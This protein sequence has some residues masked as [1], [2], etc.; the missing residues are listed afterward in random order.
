MLNRLYCGLAG[1][2]ACLFVA[3]PAWA[4]MVVVTDVLDRKV[5]V[6]KSADRILLGFYFEDF[7]AVGG[8]DAY[9]RVVA[10]SRPVWEGWRNLQWQ[11]YVAAAPKIEQLADIGDVSAGTFS[12][13]KIIAVQPDVAILAA[14]QYSALC[15]NASR[16]EAAGIPVVVIDYNAQTVEKH[17][18]STKAL[19]IV[20]GQEARAQE[21]VGLYAAAIADVERRIAGTKTRPRV[22]VELGRKGAGEVD[23]SYGDTMWGRL[24]EFAGGDNIA[25][26]QIAK[27]GP[28]SP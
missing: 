11:A 18:A 20:L 14:W 4:E 13:E 5:E 12:L 1:M 2:A 21:L 24:V 27:W 6:P 9:D 8:P 23:N 16:L 17:T 28:L 15:E 26:S 10:I 25:K 19:G 22:Y 7:F 3:L